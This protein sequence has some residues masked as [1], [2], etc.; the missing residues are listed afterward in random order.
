M[1]V[2][3]GKGVTSVFAFLLSA[4]FCVVL[5]GRTLK[6][7]PFAPGGGPKDGLLSTGIIFLLAAI[8]NYF[9]LQVGPLQD[10]SQIV[11]NQSG[12][13]VRLESVGTLFFIPRKFWTYIF[14]ALGLIFFIFGLV[15]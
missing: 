9:S 14:A 4:L 8:L 15:K 12:E 1:I 11:T 5:L 7:P 13:K 2:W 3:K 6:V 10:D